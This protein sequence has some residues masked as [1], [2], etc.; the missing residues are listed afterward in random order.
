MPNGQDLTAAPLNWSSTPQMDSR[1]FHDE[2]AQRWRY[3]PSGVFLENNPAP[4]RT[5]GNPTT[6]NAILAAY[7]TE[8]F[9][10][11]M[12]RRIPPELIVMTIAVETAVFRKVN[13]TGPKTFRWEPGVGSYSGGPMQ[14]LETTARDVIAKLHLIF[15]P[16]DIPPHFSSKPQSPPSSNPLYDGDTNITLGVDYISLHTDRTG[17][18][19]ILVAAN[20]NGG[21]IKRRSTTP[22]NPW[23]LVTFGDH[24]NRAAAWFGDACAV[25]SPLRQ[26]QTLATPDVDEPATVD[27]EDT[28]TQGFDLSGLTREEATEQGDDYRDSGASVL[29][30]PEED[31]LF[32]LSIT[33]PRPVAEPTNPPPPPPPPVAG[34]IQPPDM[35]GYVICIERRLVQG[36]TGKA[37]KRTV[38]EYQAFFNRQPIPDMHG[39]AVERQGPGDNTNTGVVNHRRLAQGT[40]PLFTHAGGSNKYRTLGYANPGGLQIRPWP[41]IRVG[42]TGAR[43]GVLIH[44]AAGFLMSIGCINLTGRDLRIGKDDLE[45]FDSRGR[46]IGLI[47]SMKSHL[48]NNFPSSNNT[49][50]VNAALVIRGEPKP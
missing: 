1:D 32:T 40:Y 14:I 11:S 50:I 26:G 13:F 45:F 7:G 10:A 3:D 15:Q 38:G 35:D 19:P 8:I 24:L 42:N 30:V 27:P 28:A 2:G 43:S 9:S 49:K 31:G 22:D 37:F 34:A 46:V 33:Y 17:L 5:A 39:N 18:D 16:Q 4:L 12:T 36:R 23:G 20:Y 6:V 48:G 41:S 21:S 29:E 44:C 47:Q 25:L